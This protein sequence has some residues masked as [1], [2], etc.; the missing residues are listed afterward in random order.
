VENAPNTEPVET[1]DEPTTGSVSVS[2]SGDVVIGAPTAIA[3]SIP[4]P[5][6][7]E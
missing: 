4:T 2:S 7:E 6:E 1:V 5:E 3:I